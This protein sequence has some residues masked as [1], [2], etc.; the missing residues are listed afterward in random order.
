LQ[1][2][3]GS[4]CQV[5]E[6]VT[7][8][9]SLAARMRGAI[10][11]GLSGN[12]S[13]KQCSLALDTGKLIV[14][15][16]WKELPM[17]LAVIDRVNVLGR[18]KRS[19]LVFTDHLVWAIGNY[20]PNVGEAGDGDDNKSVVNDLYSPVLPATSKLA[21]VSLFE[22]GSTDMIPGVDLPAVVDVVSESTGVDMGSPQ[23]D[24]LKAMLCLMMLSLIW[25]WMM[26]SKRMT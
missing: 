19:L 4:Y 17:P 9:N 6:D 26:V 2:K 16:C 21:G 3:F 12:S 18:A 23:A 22:E 25:H 8:C 7:P 11:M 1:L 24:P 5:A 20:T 14:R 13:G 10:S 15:K